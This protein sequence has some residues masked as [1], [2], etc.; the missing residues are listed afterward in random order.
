MRELWALAMKDLRL[1][2]RDKAGFFFTFFFP[3]LY[4]VV[5]GT[6]FPAGD[7]A[8]SATPIIV[9]DL[10]KSEGSRE[11][12]ESLSTGGDL[13]VTP[14]DDRAAA[15]DQVRLGKKAA[16]VV[17]PEGFGA[18]AGNIFAG[19]PMR[20]EVG[21]DPSR[22]AE[23][24]LIQG[25]LTAHAYERLQSMFTDFSAASDMAENAM[26]SVDEAS[27][28]ELPPAQR[29]ILKT[30]LGSLDHFLTALP[31]AQAADGDESEAV[32]FNPVE[33]ESLEIA[34]PPRAGP[35]SPYAV[36]F[37]QGIVWGIMGC[38]AGFGISLVTERTKGTLT[39]LR[40]APLARSR[41]LLGKALA[42]FLTTVGV[43]V[44]LLLIARFAF[45]VVPSSLPLLAAA[46]LSAAVAFVG[47]M[48]LL[49]TIGRTEAAAGGIGWAVLLVFAMFGGG[50]IPL[51]F[52]KGWM[53]TLS[54]FSPVKWAI[55][56]L[57]G[58]IWRGFTPEQMLLPCGILIG[59]GVA[60]FALGSRLF[61]WSE[62]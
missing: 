53:Q 29:A 42:C 43:A 44:M 60:G 11:F 61:D 59:I 15:L 8:P 51:M 27:D 18:A 23:A 4:A 40:T 57:E 22:A 58:A 32:A 36:S 55:Y 56:A 41:V 24:G 28:E 2:V 49:A 25:L 45:G 50:M 35:R 33:I 21:V 16:V 54:H 52:M 14:M 34:P 5:F 38:A 9:V 48:M 3:I 37:P 10:D 39:R 12:V 26:E 6:L 30:F 47:I 1:L 46:V 31:E 17:V 13:A 19:E 62:G 7:D 20:L